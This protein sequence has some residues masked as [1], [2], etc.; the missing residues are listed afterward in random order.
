[1]SGL[2]A[3]GAWYQPVTAEPSALGMLTSS[4]PDSLVSLS[5]NRRPPRSYWKLRWNRY[6]PPS[7][8]R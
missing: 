3:E 2:P 7:A 1:M 5:A 8:S 4:A 6:M